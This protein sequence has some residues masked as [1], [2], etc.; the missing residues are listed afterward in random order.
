M[1]FN[2]QNITIANH[3]ELAAAVE[4][5]AQE[6][7][8]HDGIDPFSEQFLLGLRDERLNH[9]HWFI[10]SDGKVE[11]V[12]ASDGSSAELFVV[13]GARQE[14]RGTALFDAVAPTPV[15]AHGNF[16]GAQ[17]LA[18]AK[19]LRI[20][21]HL[22]VMAIEG[23]ALKT[24]AQ[25]PDTD[26]LVANYTQSVERFGKEHVDQQWLKANNEA[27]SWHP[28]QGGWD[29]ERLHR[30]M[31]PAW[32]DEKDVIFFWDV[33]ANAEETTKEST[34]KTLPNMAGFHWTKWHDETEEGFGEV[35]VVGL[36]DAYRGRRLGGPLLNAGLERMAEKGADRVIL[37]VEADN[38][39]AV[40]AYERLGFEIAENHVVYETSDIP[41]ED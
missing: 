22:L 13:P 1:T 37:Y 27:F 9:Q 29:M 28:E 6:T 30:G 32:F 35:Y 31:E 25:K 20:T 8:K 24:A 23:E 12:A 21:R 15:W 36:A 11:A 41:G 18:K 39:P 3:P 40:K 19:D 10:E 17:A 7:G 4:T 16:A 33:P 34:E 38:G 2:V 14:G 5:A 26:L